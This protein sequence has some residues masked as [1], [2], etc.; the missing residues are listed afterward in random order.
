MLETG[1]ATRARTSPKFPAEKFATKAPPLAPEY[2]PKIP[3][4]KFATK[5]PPLAPEYFPEIPSK[6]FATKASH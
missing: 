6:K 2:F 4:E 1:E 3:S 5:A